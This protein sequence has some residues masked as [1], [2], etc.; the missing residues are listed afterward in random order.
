MFLTA[1]VV[2]GLLTVSASGGLVAGVIAA[3]RKTKAIEAFAGTVPDAADDSHAATASALSPY[4]TPA[5]DDH[6]GAPRKRRG[7]KLH[8]HRYDL[9]IGRTLFR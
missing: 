8:H 2:A 5:I 9:M 6:A 7:G 3:R 4:R 1:L